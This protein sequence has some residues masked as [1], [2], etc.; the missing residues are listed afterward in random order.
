M[1][2]LGNIFEKLQCLSYS[3]KRQKNQRPRIW[4][5]GSST[6]QEIY[7]LLMLLDEQARMKGNPALID[8]IDIMATDISSSALFIAL[9][10][11]YD[12]FSIG[13]GLADIKKQKYFTQEGNVWVF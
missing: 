9:S 6:G 1:K 7:S 8:N 2:L 5:A 4:S 13:R 10:A 3:I 12:S 11:R